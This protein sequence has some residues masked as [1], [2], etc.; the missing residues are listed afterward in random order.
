MLT[1]YSKDILF[2]LFIISDKQS[3]VQNRGPPAGRRG[4]GSLMATPIPFLCFPFQ[5][6]EIG[7]LCGEIWVHSHVIACD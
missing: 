5:S 6:I 3:A 7:G 4:V 1:I 2:P